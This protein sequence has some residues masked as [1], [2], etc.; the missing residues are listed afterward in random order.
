MYGDRL[1]ENYCLVKY[2]N[3][4]VLFLGVIGII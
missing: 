2:D 1:L 3:F 4:L